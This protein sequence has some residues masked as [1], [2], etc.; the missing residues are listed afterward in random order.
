MVYKSSGTKSTHAYCSVFNCLKATNKQNSQ[1]KNLKS[2]NFIYL[3][4]T[5]FVVVVVVVFRVLFLT[6]V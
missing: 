2:K 1:K 6:A 5:S 4:S 3:K